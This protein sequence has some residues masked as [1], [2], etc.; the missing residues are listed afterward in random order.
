MKDNDQKLW[1][2][3]QAPHFSLVLSHMLI[4]TDWT[5]T[6]GRGRDLTSAVYST[7]SV[8]CKPVCTRTH[9]TLRVLQDVSQ[10]VVGSTGYRQLR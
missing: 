8:C 2:R 6:S 3:T 7:G 10:Q 9:A 1:A 5:S 4:G